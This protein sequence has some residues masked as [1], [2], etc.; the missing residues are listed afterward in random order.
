MRMSLKIALLMSLL[1]VGG[2]AVAA[3]PCDGWTPVPAI[4]LAQLRGGFTTA[5]GLSVQL[6]IERLLSV[7]GDVMG[8]TSI[9]FENGLVSQASAVAGVGGLIQNGA[10]NAFLARLSD[11]SGAGIFIQNSLNEQTIASQTTIDAAVSSAGLLNTLHFH[12]SLSD[13]IARAAASR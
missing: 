7:N 2:S 11:L 3:R 12:S 8:R 6:G 10:N 9:H 4:A 13:A 5:Q 1:N